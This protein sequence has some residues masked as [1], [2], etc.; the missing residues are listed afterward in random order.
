[1]QTVWKCLCVTFSTIG[2]CM[3]KACFNLLS[4]YSYQYI[5][6]VWF[7]NYLYVVLKWIIFIKKSE[8]CL[9]WFFEVSSLH[10]Y[11]RIYL[12]TIYCL[13]LFLQKSIW[14]Q[15]HHQC[16]KYSGCSKKSSDSW[17]QKPGLDVAEH[18]VFPCWTGLSRFLFFSSP[19]LFLFLFSFLQIFHTKISADFFSP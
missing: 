3:K 1:M 12:H 6:I 16:R 9:M 7:N 18:A 17:S 14:H 19:P 11:Y 8:N 10:S 2:Y 13:I 4:I 5:C 15:I